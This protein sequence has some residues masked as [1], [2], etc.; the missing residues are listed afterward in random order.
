MAKP[1]KKDTT[2]KKDTPQTKTGTQKTSSLKKDAARSYTI[3]FIPAKW[4]TPVFLAVILILILIF[5][6]EGLFGGKVFSSAD[7]V[8]SGSFKTFLDDAKAKGEFPLWVPYIFNGMPSFAALVPHLERMYDISHAVWV[9]VRDAL[10]LLFSGNEVWSIVLFYIIF[11]FSFYFLALYKFKDKLIA[12]YC[13][14][15]AV[16]ITPII[17]MII[18]GHNSKMIAVMMFPSVFLMLEK[19]YDMIAEGRI[20][21]NIFRLLLY[22]GLL[23]F[24][25]H[26]QMSSNHVQ[27]LFYFFSGIGIYLVYRLVYNLIKKVNVKPAVI[28]LCVFILGVGLSAMMY[29]DSYLSSREYNKYSIRGVPPITQ[30]VA[31]QKTS[32]GAGDYEYSTNWSFSP[33]ET[34]TF[35]VPYWVGFGDVEVKG[36][37]ANTYWGQMPFTT[38]PMYFGVITILLAFIGI[39]YNFKKSIIVQAMVIISFLSLILSFGRTLPILYDILFYNLPYF[40]SFRAPVMI[41]ILINVAFVI[42]AG[43]GIKSVIDITRDKAQSQRFLNAAKFVFPILALPVLISVIG[44]QDYYTSQVQSS[45]LLQKL[46]MQGASTQQ[47]QQYVGQISQIAYDNVKSEL[48]VVGFLL[49]ITYALCYF[50]IK[51]NIKYQIFGLALI[52]IMVVDLWHID[53]KT[54][55]WDNK[56]DMQANFKTP[57]YVDWILK[58][59]NN[60]NEFRVL[61]LNSGQPVRENTLAYWRLQ[62][63][64]GY[65][66]AKLR[67]YQDMDDIVGMINPS[68]W[69]IMSTKYIITD[70]P[71]NDSQFTPV[72]KGSKYVLRNNAFNPK[73]FFVGSYKVADGITTLN[74]IKDPSFDPKK[75]SY[76]E[77]EPGTKIDAADSTAKAQITAYDIHNIT[78]D[79]EATGN[80]LLFVSEVYYPDWKV[81]IDGQPA[82]I[83]KMNYLFRG[84]VVPKG[85]HKIEF[86]FEPT[87]YYTGKNISIGTNFLLI[88]IFAIAIGGILMRRKKSSETKERVAEVS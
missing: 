20:K 19:I 15:A 55:H 88:A 25:T 82:E 5:F 72:F 56:T 78:I 69:K 41:H 76:L 75:L 68:A 14:L 31:E 26:V 42:L 13:A 49:L 7:N 46:Q 35:F 9:T 33:V 16:F 58:N 48:L 34:M 74:S 10:Y 83:L 44:F 64:Y 22:F 11:A 37:K 61:N 43:Y 30:T 1:V 32:T 53:F 79:A 60:T 59:D 86:K 73:A 84:I 80:N 85:K 77:K 62:N 18:V 57:D 40:S 45:P 3:D 17:Q 24:F 23:V 4:Q 52:I 87:T 47:I 63:N 21:E 81:Y 51:G 2:A 66:G 8:A 67:I 29:A 28:V 65:Q 70:Q 39:Y 38:S 27:M 36:Q 50:F 12:L 71:Y 6:N 54:L